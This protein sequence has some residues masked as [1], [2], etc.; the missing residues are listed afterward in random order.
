MKKCQKGVDFI[1]VITSND[2]NY[3]K[4]TVCTYIMEQRDPLI[5]VVVKP[6]LLSHVFVFGRLKTHGDH[7]CTCQHFC[8]F[9]CDFYPFL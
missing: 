5:L 6:L 4:K 3:E 7:F 1:I 2:C 9:R 8:C